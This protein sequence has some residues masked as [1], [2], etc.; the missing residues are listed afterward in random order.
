MSEPERESP[1]AA[2]N[3][4]G[5]NR[6]RAWGLSLLA[7]ALLL[8]MMGRRYQAIVFGIL[9][10]L[11]AAGSFIGARSDGEKRSPLRLIGLAVA[12]FL[13]VAV[14][15]GSMI[16][17][18]FYRE[19]QKAKTNPAV[20]APTTQPIGVAPSIERRCRIVLGRTASVA[21]EADGGAT[22]V[23]RGASC[24]VLNTDPSRMLLRVTDGPSAGA[25]GWLAT[26]E[27]VIVR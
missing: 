26:D 17:F 8:L 16:A 3:R 2:A 4:P 18:S 1:K 6:A 20:G 19:R 13:A 11:L 24:V 22:N 7:A 10:A 25:V 21:L 14:I 15:F 27:I 23:Q 5:V 12:V 9:G